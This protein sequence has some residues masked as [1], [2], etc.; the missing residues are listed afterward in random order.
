MRKLTVC[1]A[2]ISKFCIVLKQDHHPAEKTAAEFLR[3]VIA[4]SCGVDVTVSD[5]ASEHSIFI[6]ECRRPDDVKWDGFAVCTDEKSLYLGSKEARGTLY[7]AHSFAEKYLGYRRFAQDT[8][9][10][11]TDGEA[12]V[13]CGLEIVDNPVFEVRRCD[14]YGL[15]KFPEQAA[16]ARTNTCAKLPEELGG[17]ATGLSAECHTFGKLCPADVYFDEHPEYYSLRDGKRMPCR[18]GYGPAQLCLTNDD[19]VKIVTEN[20]LKKL[21]ENPGTR[22]IDVSQSDN[23]NYCTCEKCAAVDE[24]EGSHSG[25]MIRFVNRVAEA[26]EK[27][28]PDVLIQTFAYQHT[29]HAPKY[30]VAR[31]NVIVRYCSI[32]A[33]CRHPINDPNC[34]HNRDHFYGDLFEW[35]KH[36]HLL[37]VWDYI[38][39]YRSYTAPFPNFRA[40]RENARFFADCNAIHIF[41]EDTAVTLA[42]GFADLRVYLV[43]KLMWNP[44]MSEEEYQGHI[45]D[46]LMGYYGKGWQDVRNY[47]E[48]SHDATK[49]AHMGCYA[50]ID[51][52]S[53][54]SQ[55]IPSIG[56][57]L[58]REYI[59]KAYQPIFPDSVLNDL[60]PHLEEAKEYMKKAYEAAD[61]DLHRMHIHR[62]GMEVTYLDLFC[63]PHE[64]NKMT[65]D[66]RSE[67]EAAVEQYYKDKEKYGLYYSSW[68]S[69]YGR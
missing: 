19:V 46:F 41:E 69:A 17:E 45:D 23:M 66:E 55:L 18:D 57:Y 8:E 48:L 58:C 13:P 42:G 7:A 22:V 37:S 38:V 51:V 28:F 65:P 34:Q 35:Q 33:C 25:T 47:L 9:I 2:D 26:V 40:L 1:G 63:I 29:Q 15:M 11:P 59:P 16:F 12:D 52:A 39:N 14:A 53:A 32:L 4:E 64:K 43:G 10:I 62:T 31:K 5:T 67:Y 6:G 36:S 60:Y 68:T 50:N 24:E 49:D 3:R 21:R 54:F 56:N 30:A 27:E 44:Y 61:T 20:V